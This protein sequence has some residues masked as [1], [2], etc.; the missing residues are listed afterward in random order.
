MK[1]KLRKL[2]V[3]IA[4]ITMV[5]GLM[6]SSVANAELVEYHSPDYSLGEKELKNKVRVSTNGRYIAYSDDVIFD[7]IYNEDQSES[8]GLRKV[9]LLDR[10]TGTKVFERDLVSE[11]S[12]RACPQQ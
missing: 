4:Q 2:C 1:M 7:E 12:V 6:A 11:C 3:A 9:S 10:K 8:W 5:G